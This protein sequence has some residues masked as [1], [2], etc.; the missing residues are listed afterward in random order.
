M[1]DEKL[2]KQFYAPAARY[3]GHE[4]LPMSVHPS[5]S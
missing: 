4:V 5:H 3:Q 2:G 1:S